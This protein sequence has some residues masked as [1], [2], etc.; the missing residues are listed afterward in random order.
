MSLSLSHPVRLRPMS[1]DDLEFV[2]RLE[3]D[4]EQWPFEESVAPCAEAVY[5]KY[6]QELNEQEPR[7]HYNDI[8]EIEEQGEWR[9]IGMMQI[10]S[11]VAHRK[12]W[13]IGYALASP[14]E[15][16]GYA[17]RALHQML[18]FAFEELHAHKVVAMC[19]EDNIRSIQLL[20][21]VGMRREG[22]FKEELNW[23]GQWKDQYFYAILEHEYKRPIDPQS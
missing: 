5:D 21:R 6:R 8:V 4:P 19:H 14:Y 13:E 23:R 7:E 11:Y 22:I 20:E 12:S 2:S 17:T 3:C 1:L 18:Q 10:W 15:G 16:K 9:S